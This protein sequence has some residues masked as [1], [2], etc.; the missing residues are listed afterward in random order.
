MEV[1]LKV[2]SLAFASSEFSGPAT[3][4]LPSSCINAHEGQK[5][6]ILNSDPTFHNV[7]AHSDSGTVFN[8]PQAQKAAE[9]FQTFS[10]TGSRSGIGC[11]FHSWMASYVG[12]FEHPFH[13]T[14]GET[15][16]FE[17][18]LPPGKYELV[19]WHER[20][21]EQVSSLEVAANSSREVNFTFSVPAKE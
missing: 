16:K 13:T 9:D 7:H 2:S 20:L 10:R 11:D 15:G 12:V 6:R 4:R 8:I 1:N 3:L 18:R 17:L 21:G 5:L 19:A 14:T